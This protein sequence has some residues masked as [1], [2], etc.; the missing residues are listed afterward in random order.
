MKKVVK[1]I[2][3]PV[4]KLSAQLCGDCIW[5]DRSSYDKWKDGYYCAQYQK[6][7]KL[8]EDARYC[9]KYESR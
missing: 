3:L 7:Y 2:R 8:T 4:G 5:M 1:Y 6:Y 9:K